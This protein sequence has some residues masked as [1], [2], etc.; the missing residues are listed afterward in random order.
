MTKVNR[1]RVA[2]IGLD[3]Y[4]A[5][6]IEHLCG[7]LRTTDSIESYLARYSLT[8]TDVV[9]SGTADHYRIV[10]DIHLLTVGPVDI[11]WLSHDE[12]SIHTASQCRLRTNTTNTEREVT[13]PSTCPELYK[14][15]ASDL[16][17][18]PK[19]AS[20]PHTVAF[21]SFDQGAEETKLAETTS[22]YPVAWRLV[23]PLITEYGVSV[24]PAPTV[25]VLPQVTNLAAWFSAFLADIHEIDP[26]RVPQKPPR[27]SRPS[28]WHTPEER[29][30]EEQIS[31]ITHEINRLNEERRQFQ[32]QL[33]TEGEKADT[34]IRRIVWADGDDLVAAA[35]EILAEFGFCVGDMDAGLEPGEPKREDLR[36][37]LKNQENWE[38][39]VEVKGY[40][41]GTKTNDSRQIREHREEYITEKGKRPDLTVWLANPFRERDPSSRPATDNNVRDAAANIGT[42]HVLATDLYQQWVLV[43]TGRLDAQA[44]VQHLIDAEPGLW[45][46]LVNSN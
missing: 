35:K 44:V 32:I 29:V 37:T 41:N 42:V 23:L 26:D 11:E 8:E 45:T 7:A 38:A 20:N 30:L 12:P 28:D 43:K 3:S 1:P 31:K 27:L 17:N 39:L 15:L 2:A 19:T 36:L 21:L 6:S 34:G 46:P 25:L 33:A 16:V 5:E 4:Q 9:V 14:A 22:G 10:G 24:K 40:S 18:L 13:V